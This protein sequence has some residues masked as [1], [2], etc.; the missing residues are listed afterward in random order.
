[1]S[2]PHIQE[3]MTAVTDLL[4]AVVSFYACFRLRHRWKGPHPDERWYLLFFLLMGVSTVF[5]AFMNHAFA[6]VF[7]A[8]DRNCLP[9]WTTNALA[10][11]CYALAMVERAHQV[12]PLAL[13]KILLTAIVIETL[14]ILVLTLW[15]MSFLY[16]EIHIAVILYAFS[17]P[18]QVRLWKGGY[19]REN[20]LAWSATALM[21]LIPVV[22]VARLNFSEHFNF[23]DISHVII[24]T[25]IYLYYRAGQAWRAGNVAVA[26]E[27]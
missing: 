15:K 3:P 25:A 19:R 23:F 27:G 7:P 16:A 13:R 5:G 12:Q 21:T 9:N 20:I 4:I 24:A 2:F 22:L 6:Y 26:I 8:G 17:L 11:S 10:V 18:L 14:A 1:M